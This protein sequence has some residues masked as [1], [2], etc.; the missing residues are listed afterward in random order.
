MGD[1]LGRAEMG[2]AEAFFEADDAVLQLEVVDAALDGENEQ[3]E[4]DDDG[5]VS[6]V[7]ILV[8][9]V[10][11]DVDGDAEIDHENWEDEE[12][13]GWIEA[14][15]VLIGLWSSHKFPFEGAASA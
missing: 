3:R 14:R 10:D 8:A 5:P 9:E 6:E 15:V 12:V 13:H 11:G 1:I 7:G 4:R 2:D